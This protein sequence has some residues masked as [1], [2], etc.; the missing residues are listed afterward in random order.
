MTS[1]SRRAFLGTASAATVLRPSASI[2]N[3]AQR[4]ALRLTGA[5]YVRFMPLATGDLKPAE[6]DLTWIRGDRT[7]MLRRAT[8]DPEVDGG[9]SSM[10]QHIVRI[11][12]G[13]RSLV[14]VPVFPLRNFTARDLY[15]RKG[16]TVAPDKLSGKRIGIYSW[17]ASGAVWY[18][19]LVRHLGNDFASIRWIVGGADS[20]APVPQVVALPANVT[21]AAGK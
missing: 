12:A 5:N 8:S 21:P 6:L 14:A 3:A 2:A 19:H 16:S 15:T 18:R 20:T 1:L 11:D 17:A 4:P 10:A 9:E 13:D 7:E